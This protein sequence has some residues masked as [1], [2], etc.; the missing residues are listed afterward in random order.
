M[1]PF[2]LINVIIIFIASL[3]PLDLKAKSSTLKFLRL[4]MI[5]REEFAL[6]SIQ[7]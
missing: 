7:K 5:R 6:Q 2:I 1:R 4:V 3:T